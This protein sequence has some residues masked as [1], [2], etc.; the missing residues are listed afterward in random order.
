MTASNITARNPFIRQMLTWTFLLLVALLL[1]GGWWWVRKPRAY[2][3]VARFPIYHDD[4]DL[5]ILLYEGLQPCVDGFCLREGKRAFTFRDWNT[6]R[7]RWRV[8]TSEPD[9]RGWPPPED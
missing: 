3:P 8:T 4:F 5:D 2:R 9:S 7:L 1:V 6:G